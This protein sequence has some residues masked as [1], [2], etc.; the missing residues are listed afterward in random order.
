[1]AKWLYALEPHGKK[2][3]EISIGSRWGNTSIR[4]NG[5]LIGTVD[6][7]KEL[8]AGKEFTLQDG[9]TLKVKL[10]KSNLQ[11]FRNGELLSGGKD[12]AR[13]LRM[14]CG[15][16]YVLGGFYILL[17]CIAYISELNKSFIPRFEYLG[18]TH[19]GIISIVSGCILVVLGLL[20]RRRSLGALIAAVVVGSAYTAAMVSFAVLTA[21]TAWERADNAVS[22]QSSLGTLRQAD[23][24]AFFAG[25][26]ILVSGLALNAMWNG[27]SAIKELRRDAPPR[28]S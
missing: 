10:A 21:V 14:C 13:R 4:L 20:T 18:P 5:D 6:T 16:I 24:D 7:R 22:A 17:G 27:V 1:V 23:D 2:S 15:A 12:P 11:V 3:V 28:A 9:S 19:Y 8:K 26:I 25:V